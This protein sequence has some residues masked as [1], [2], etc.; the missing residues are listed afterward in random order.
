MQLINLILPC[1]YSSAL[2][3]KSSLEASSASAAETVC[4]PVSAAH[5]AYSTKQRQNQQHWLRK[6]F[7]GNFSSTKELRAAQTRVSIS[8]HTINAAV[9]EHEDFGAKRRAAIALAH[10][11][12]CWNIHR[13]QEML[14]I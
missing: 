3:W 4:S 11:V 5:I 10:D 7:S 13:Q 8:H 1:H 9:I 2:S 6:K 14:K 12:T